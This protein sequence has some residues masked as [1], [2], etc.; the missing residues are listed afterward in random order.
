LRS[1]AQSR[2]RVATFIVWLSE[3]PKSA[4]IND[5]E[6]DRHILRLS[7]RKANI[8]PQSPSLCLK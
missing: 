6:D 7:R 5:S 8:P 4:P 1:G 2:A 3:K